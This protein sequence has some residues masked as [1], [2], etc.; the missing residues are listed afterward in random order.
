MSVKFYDNDGNEI[1]LLV[2][3]F[4]E[5]QRQINKWGVQNHKSYTPFD[6]IRHLGGDSLSNAVC[7]NSKIVTDIKAEMRSVSYLD[8][9][10]E[11]VMEAR[12][13]AINGDLEN[14]QIELIQCAA[15]ALSWIEC[16]RR[17]RH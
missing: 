11:E 1:T 3:T 9:F 7:E 13:E 14:L 2:E 5:M 4:E 15:V 12:E 10:L 8:I 6:V 16:I 17:N